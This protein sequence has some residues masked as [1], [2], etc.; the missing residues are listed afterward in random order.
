MA[1]FAT[2]DP[3]ASALQESAAGPIGDDRFTPRYVGHFLTTRLTGALQ[4]AGALLEAQAPRDVGTVRFSWRPGMGGNTGD[5]CGTGC[6]EGRY[7]WIVDIHRVPWTSRNQ[8]GDRATVVYP[9]TWI[10]FY[11][12]LAMMEFGHFGSLGP[13]HMAGLATMGSH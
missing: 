9:A 2:I 3:P 4:G 10:G 8:G 13:G 12:A 5:G 7:F 1:R 6:D 11:V